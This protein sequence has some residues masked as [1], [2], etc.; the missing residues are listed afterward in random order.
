MGKA[1]KRWFFNLSIRSKIVLLIYTI[2]L[3][4]FISLSLILLHIADNNAKKI[5]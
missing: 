1:L 3:V 4:M 5:L 2:I